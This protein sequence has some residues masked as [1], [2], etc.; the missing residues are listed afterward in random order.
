MLSAAGDLLFFKLT[1]ILYI[2]LG[3]VGVQYMLLEF[4]GRQYFIKS[5]LLHLYSKSSANLLPTLQ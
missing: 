3:S 2:S 5:S 1:I 4:E